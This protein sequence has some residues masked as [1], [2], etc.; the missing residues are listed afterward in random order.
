MDADGE[1]ISI[2]R[3]EV[4]GTNIT[5]L[6]F[7]AAREENMFTIQSPKALI[8]LSSL[9]CLDHRALIKSRLLQLVMLVP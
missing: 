3:G 7:P 5:F 1:R 8:E 9:M 6:V 2:K 4:N